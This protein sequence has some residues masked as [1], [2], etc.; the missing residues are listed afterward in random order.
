MLLI[1]FENA[2][3]S[4]HVEDELSMGKYFQPSSNESTDLSE[5]RVSLIFAHLRGPAAILFT[6]RDT[7]SDSIAKLFRACFHG[8]G[9]RTVIARQDAKWGITEICLY[10]AKY[11]GGDI[12]QFRGSATLPQQVLHD[13]GYRGDGIAISRDVEPPSC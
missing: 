3:L 8:G 9:Y 11:Q 10:E 5:H 1:S 4:E 7:C 2:S 13:M 12:A 6:S